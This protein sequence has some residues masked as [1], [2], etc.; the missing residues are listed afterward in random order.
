MS[1]ESAHFQLEQEHDKATRALNLLVNLETVL[2]EEGEAE[3]AR[4]VAGAV[5]V[6]NKV[7]E[8]LEEA[9]DAFTSP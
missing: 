1:R 2:H 5:H 9:L 4:L 6:Q 3:A 8:Q 7:C